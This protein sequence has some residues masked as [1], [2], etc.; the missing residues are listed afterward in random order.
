MK[1][2]VKHRDGTVLP[3]I[4]NAVRRERSGAIV[5]DLALSIGRDRDVYERELVMSREELRLLVHEATRLEEQA[6]DRALFAEQ[7]V[8]I[9]SH[10]L[11]NPLSAI[12]L[13]LL[14][15][16][17]GALN[18]NQIRILGRISQSTERA[19]RLIADLLDFTA[20][21]VGK[22]LK[23]SPRPIDLHTHVAEAL[24]EL[25]VAYPDRRIDHL[26]DGAQACWADPDR[27][28]QMLGNL[29][30]NAVS[31][32]DPARAITVSSLVSDDRGAQ[33]E[34]H[35][36]GP[37]IPVATVEHLFEPMV[38]GDA[39]GAARSVGLGLYIVRQ[40]IEAHGGHV[41]VRS[42]E[43]A[44]TAFTANFPLDPASRRV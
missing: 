8:G 19:H 35:N 9:V 42:T 38:R 24:E 30:S 5:H 14:A 13:G 7:M 29:V 31:Y 1:L 22:G 15:L 3:M 27:L 4:L 36:F 41:I 32:G 20:A 6:K 17:R 28:A 18:S 39:S 10:D 12:H 43:A 40:I 16:S 23:V 44:G 26:Q 21:R 33:V 11:R 34:V 25:R 37:P 2:E